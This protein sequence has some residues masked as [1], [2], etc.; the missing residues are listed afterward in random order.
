MDLVLQ[1]D[2][3]SVLL[4]AA[5]RILAGHVKFVALYFALYFFVQLVVTGTYVHAGS[6]GVPH[7]LAGIR[8]V[9]NRD[10]GVHTNREGG[11][12]RSWR[13]VVPCLC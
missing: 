13:A 9:L 5:V 10:C 8:D 12:S 4:A 11:T 1:R 3:C 6:V 2:L 7:E